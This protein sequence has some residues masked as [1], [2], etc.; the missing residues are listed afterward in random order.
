LAV[1][2]VNTQPN[3]SPLAHD[4]ERYRRQRPAG[5]EHA[6]DRA[7][8]PVG[9]RHRDEAQR[10]QRWQ[11]YLRRHR[12]QHGAGKQHAHR[13]PA[14]PFLAASRPGQRL[15]QQRPGG[16]DAAQRELGAGQHEAK[17]QRLVMDAGDE[18]HEQQR[19]GRAEPQRTHLG[20]AAA[21][22]QPRGGPHD[23]PDTGEHHKAVTKHRFDDV[24]AGQP[25][26]T[27]SDP[28]K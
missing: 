4:R 25:R 11:F 1:P 3:P 17:H 12:D 18:V 16:V 5:H 26:D 2:K 28:K 15:G 23:E 8:P 19:V 22:G 9:E 7:A 27:A 24:L 10:Q 21:P 6:L 14:R 20:H 13:L